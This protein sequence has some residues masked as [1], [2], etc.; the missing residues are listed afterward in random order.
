MEA[1]HLAILGQLAWI[2]P[3]AASSSRLAEAIQTVCLSTYVS[4][5]RLLLER[6]AIGPRRGRRYLVESLRLRGGWAYRLVLRTT[7][8]SVQVYRTARAA[9]PNPRHPHCSCGRVS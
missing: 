5:L 7:D 9:V 8:R 6:R 2:Y 3:A 1:K 4:R